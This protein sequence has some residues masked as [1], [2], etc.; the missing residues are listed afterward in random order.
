MNRGNI[1][2]I[3]ACKKGQPNVLFL[4]SKMI[5]LVKMSVIQRSA[6]GDWDACDSRP[7]G[8]RED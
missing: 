7:F 4:L 1:E 8:I 3:W 2:G 5:H 6:T